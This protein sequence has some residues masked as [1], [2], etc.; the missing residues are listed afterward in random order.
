MNKLLY[1]IKPIYVYAAMDIM[2]H[3]SILAIYGIL[4]G[5]MFGWIGA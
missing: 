3:A 4:L 2:Y 5:F 1:K